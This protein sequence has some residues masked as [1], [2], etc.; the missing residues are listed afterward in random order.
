MSEQH[1]YEIALA[2]LR[3]RKTITIP[4]GD[5]FDDV[6]IVHDFANTLVIDQDGQFIMMS[7]EMLQAAA[8]WVE[9]ETRL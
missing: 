9:R 5:D 6:R 4:G 8:K 2:R 3:A 1:D 7:P